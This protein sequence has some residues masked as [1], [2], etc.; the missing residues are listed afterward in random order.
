MSDVLSRLVGHNLPY[1]LQLIHELQLDKDFQ[2]HDDLLIISDKKIRKIVGF[3]LKYIQKE[4]KSE[5][6]IALKHNTENAKELFTESI[7]QLKNIYIDITEESNSDILNADFLFQMIQNKSFNKQQMIAMVTELCDKAYLHCKIE[8]SP[9]LDWKK[10]F[11]IE[12]NETPDVITTYIHVLYKIIELFKKQRVDNMNI[13]LLIYKKYFSGIEGASFEREQVTKA[14]T[15]GFLELESTQKWLKQAE[16]NIPINQ[17]MTSKANVISIHREAMCNLLNDISMKN[18]IVIASEK[19]PELLILDS[20][21]I[22]SVCNDIKVLSSSLSIRIICKAVI[23]YPITDHIFNKILE[24]M[25]KRKPML[26]NIEDIIYEHIPDVPSDLHIM[27]KKSIDNKPNSIRGVITKRICKY[28]IHKDEHETIM[29]IQEQ[30][31]V[32]R[33]KIIKLCEHYEMVYLPFYHVL[34]YN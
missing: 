26:K 14:I 33:D 27:L 7:E 16:K 9:I 4:K 20:H 2:F 3:L 15:A 21:R 24:H 8:N 19:L 6:C 28:I 23:S 13:K 25:N 31:N 18:Q 29:D 32:I 30:M 34:L 1:G 11:L 22:A 10:Q 5:L 12:L 17:Q